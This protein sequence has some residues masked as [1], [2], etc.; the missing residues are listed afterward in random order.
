M[1]KSTSN[2]TYDIDDT[3]KRTENSYRKL[4]GST[5]W[6]LTESAAAKLIQEQFAPD[7]RRPPFYIPV[8]NEVKILKD[9]LRDS[10]P[11]VLTGPPGIGKTTLIQ[12][13]FHELGI[14]L[15]TFVASASTQTHELLGRQGTGGERGDLAVWTDGKLSL[16]ARAAEGGFTNGL[17]LDEVINLPGNVA[18]CMYSILDN[19]QSLPLPTGEEIFCG[20]R[21]K[22]VF[23]YN[24]S[25]TTKLEPALHS[26]LTAI[27]IGYPPERIEV[28]LLMDQRRGRLHRVGNG[29]A[30]AKG[31]AKFANTVRHAFGAEVDGEFVDLSEAEK[32][33]V[34]VIPSP[35]SS[36]SL[37][38][39]SRM[40]A[41]GGYNTAD[42]IASFIIPS[43]VQDVHDF[44]LNKV[45]EFLRHL[46]RETMVEAGAVAPGRSTVHEELD[47]MMEH[48]ERAAAEN[49]ADEQVDPDAAALAEE[50]LR[51]WRQ[52]K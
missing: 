19:R 13:V 49:R 41:T 27:R 6:V 5:F 50:I 3:I 38:V 31:M 1:A 34:R 52:K 23:S 25:R 26:R 37:I 14:P 48:Y 17:Y 16:A 44:D 32:D 4:R 2:A 24:P 8:G 11:V 29:E 35:P 10:V 40:I 12:A 39:A 7:P 22:M 43:L 18:S 42:A 15:Q 33:L 20:R 21:L 47:T 28:Q 30:V 36:R 45:L 9:L 46:A 51:E